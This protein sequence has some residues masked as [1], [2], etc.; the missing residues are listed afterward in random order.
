MFDYLI[1]VH[2]GSLNETAVKRQNTTNLSQRPLSDFV[3]LD[4]A[5]FHFMKQKDMFQ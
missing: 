5:A 4:S 3:V 2:I 1:Y